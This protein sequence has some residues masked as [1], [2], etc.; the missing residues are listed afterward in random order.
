[1]SVEGYLRLLQMTKNEERL[2]LL[3]VHNITN[4]IIHLT[5]IIRENMQAIM[6]NFYLNSDCISLSI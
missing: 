4:A 5:D 1:M 6:A 2:L 3:I